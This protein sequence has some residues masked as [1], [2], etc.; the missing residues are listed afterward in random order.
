[1]ICHHIATYLCNVKMIA[2]EL[3]TAG[4]PVDPGAMNASIFNNLGHDYFEVV[5][6]MTILEGGP[7]SF[8]SL[9]NILTTHEIRLNHARMVELAPAT[10]NQ[11]L[12][13][14]NLTSV[15]GR[16]G[17]EGRRGGCGNS[18]GVFGGGRGGGSGNYES[19]QQKR[20]D[21]CPICTLHDHSPYKCPFKMQTT[22]TV[23]H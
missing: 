10:S 15:A 9:T 14:V 20:Q 5:A 23:S 1:M 16:G 2:D 17:F 22:T 11:S 12:I 13:E 6:A 19:A 3:A 21:P 7:L 8:T 18:I 4:R